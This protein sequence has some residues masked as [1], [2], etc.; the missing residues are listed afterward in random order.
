MPEA[1][2][3]ER[4]DR[5]AEKGGFEE[6][7]AALKA[8]VEADVDALLRRGRANAQDFEALE[9]AVH[10]RALDAADRIIKAAGVQRS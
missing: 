2:L 8:A 4:L 5:A 10:R 9:R 7:L 1:Q 6:T 3:T